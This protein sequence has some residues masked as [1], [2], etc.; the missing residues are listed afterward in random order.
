MSLPFPSRVPWTCT[1]SRKVVCPEIVK[2]PSTLM[3]ERVFDPP[4]AVE[5][6]WA[7]FWRWKFRCALTYGLRSRALLLRTMPPPE[8]K[9]PPLA[10]P[11]WLGRWTESVP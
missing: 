2:R 11:D 10:V 4:P 3:R 9:N 8:P 1:A 6:F 7:T 5:S